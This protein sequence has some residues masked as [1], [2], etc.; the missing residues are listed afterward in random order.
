MIN[1]N[2]KIFVA[3]HNGL[4]GSA[5][6]RKLK[7]KGFKKI[8]TIAKSKLNLTN[9]SNVFNFLK[10][11]KPKFIFI[12]AAKVGGIYSNNKFKAEFIYSN[13][14]IQNNIIHAAYKC[15]IKNL[16]FLGSSCVYP[17]L[18]KQPIKEEYLLSGVLEKT[19]E[20]YAIAKI[21]GIKMCESYN[22]QYKTNY[23]C[24][25]PTNTFGPNDN[26]DSLNSHFFPSLIK[27]IH[28][29][30]KNRKNTLILWGDGSPKRE[31]IFVDDVAEACV[32]FMNKRVKE[33]LINIGTGK[34][35]TIKEYAKLL[36]NIIYPDKKVLIKLDKTK[37]NGT[38]RKVLNINLA[39]RYG[40]VAKTDINKAIRITYK[41]YLAKSS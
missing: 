1:K 37:P 32:F 5:I 30:K 20:P 40:W 25:M 2:S 35:F 38:P 9:Q 34:D 31:L 15:N 3:G 41:D 24:L 27:K 4:V 6:V 21:A 16:I 26:Y 17:K 28:T 13:L 10:K 22:F 33:S 8:I 11:N 39:K 7:E 12:A 29:I 19:N 18:C 14:S 23:K 36:L